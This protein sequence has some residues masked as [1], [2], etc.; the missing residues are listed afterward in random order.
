LMKISNGSTTRIVGGYN[1]QSWLSMGGYNQSAPG[2]YAAFIFNLTNNQIWRQTSSHQTYNSSSYGPTFGGGHDIYV[3]SS[4]STGYSFSTSYGTSTH[5]YNDDL[6]GESGDWTILEIEVFK[7]H[8]PRILNDETNFVTRTHL[9]QLQD[10]LGQGSFTLYNTYTKSEDDTSADF[11]SAVDGV[12]PT[13]NLMK[14]SNGSSTRIIGGYNPQSWSSLGGYNRSPTSN[15]YTAFIFNLSSNQIWRQSLDFQTYNHPSHGPTF[16]GGHDIY[17]NSSLSTGYSLVHSYGTPTGYNSDLLGHSD[18]WTILE[19]E[20]FA[21]ADSKIIGNQTNFITQ[22]HLDQLEAWLG[23]GSFTLKNIYT[24]STGD[25]S[26]DFHNAVDG[27]GPT[28]NLMKIFNGTTTRIVGGYNPQSW[29]SMGGYNTSASPDDYTAFIFNLTDTQIWRQSLDFQTY[30]HT[31]YGPTFGGGHDIYV[32]SSLSTGY[33]NG[34]SYGTSTGY[35]SDLL[36]RSGD[37]TILELEVF[38]FFEC[39]YNLAGDANKDCKVDFEDFALMAS[40]W[41]I[42]CAMNP[43]DPACVPN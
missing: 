36:G 12:G 15:F 17:V 13:F 16:G 7:F 4:L 43:S 26:T 5:N 11:H 39:T 10:W 22:S 35:N 29:S 40:S 2:D 41:L 6:L 21:F 28:F 33:S 24:K 38:N 23:E 25:D 27:Q 9:D 37:W 3:D 20:V 18:D 19:I 14:I 30:N 1:P 32:D 42:D 31:S 34:H 8:D